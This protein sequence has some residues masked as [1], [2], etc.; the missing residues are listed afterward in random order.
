MKTYEQFPDLEIVRRIIQGEIELFEIIIRRYNSP[1]YKVGRSYNYNHEDTQDLMQDTYIDAFTSLSKFENRSTLKTWL[2][3]IMLNNCYKRQQKWSSKN[4]KIGELNEK[5]IPM[6][7]NYQHS[8]TSK[9]IINRELSIVIENA[10]QQIPMDYRMVFSLRVANGL[11]VLETAN[12][13]NI[14]ED[15]VK[16]RLNRAKRM[17]RKEVE[18]SYSIED[19]YEFNLIYC[20]RMVE[21]VMNKLKNLNNLS[22]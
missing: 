6:F 19:I 16:V 4:I 1:L 21:N 14:S 13:L 10:L 17:L 3:K 22:Q 18:K 9:M 7:S 12:V 20:D 5:S 8:D 11:N 2:I 15:N